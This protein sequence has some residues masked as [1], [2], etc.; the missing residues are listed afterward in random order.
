MC[1]INGFNFRNEELIKK[2]VGLTRYRGPDQEGFYFDENISLGHARLSIIDLSEKGRQPLWNEDKSVG[3]VFNGEI[4]NFKEIKRYLENRGHLFSS[5][6][7]TEVILHLYEEKGENCLQELNGIFSFAIYDRKKEQLFL[8]RDRAGVKPL[9]YHFQEGKFIFSS[10]IKAIL[11]HNISREIDAQ[12]LNYY[13]K[14]F[15]VPAPFTLFEGIK[16]LPPAHYLLLKRGQLTI[17]KYWYLV[18]LPEIK[19]EAEAKEGIKSL[20]RE[21][22]KGQLISDRPVG[23]F[24]SGGIDSSAVLGLAVEHMPEKVKTYSVGFNIDVE[25]EKFNADFNLA[26]QTS[27]HYQTDHHELLVSGKDAADNLEKVVWHME[28][29]V[30]NPTQIPTFLLAQEAKKQ[31]AVVLGG[32]GGDELFGGYMRYYYSRLIDYYQLLPGVLKQNIFPG[33]LE[34]FSGKKGLKEK[35][36]TPPGVLRYLLFMSQ[37]GEMLS[38]VLRLPWEDRGAE[39]FL[40]DNYPES[41]F[42]DPTKYLMFLD[43]STWLPDESLVRSDKMTMA[44]GLEERVPILDHRLVEFAFKIPT[45]FKV[46]GKNKT[47]W[48]FREAMKEYLPPHLRTQKK[49]GWVSPAAKWL[50]KELKDLAYGV[51]SPNYCQGTQE[52]FNFKEIKQIL[53]NHISQKEYNLDIIWSLLTFQIWYKKFI[54]EKLT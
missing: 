28:E 38:R 37:K 33:L 50:R 19:T 11:A 9:Y 30:P 31:V 47:K 48:I 42:Q 24:L 8:A 52:Y 13:F 29:P 36:N 7:D 44:F 35:L 51:L 54:K 43:F 16:K 26:R 49:R 12:A 39:S 20:L 18:E 6:T 27:R 17:R 53:D 3:I 15:F 1:S 14:M 10:E 34:F 5:D 22:I 23:I 4:Y 45:K 32:D 46:K 40:I 21:S 2:M 41:K 25:K